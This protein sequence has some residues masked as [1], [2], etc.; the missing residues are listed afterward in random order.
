MRWIPRWRTGGRLLLLTGW[1]TACSDPEPTPPD[2][3]TQDAGTDAGTG[4][5]HGR[6]Q[7][8]RGSA[9][10]LRVRAPAGQHAAPGLRGRPLRLR[11][12]PRGARRPRDST[13]HH[14]AA[15]GL[16]R[17][18]D[19]REPDAGRMGPLHA[20]PS[21]LTRQPPCSLGGARSRGAADSLRGGGGLPAPDAAG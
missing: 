15:R 16:R 4:P 5:P 9:H 3:G 13:G 21:H 8:P 2:A 20:R 11:L 7:Q 19:A 17:A 10:P 18:P 12:V 6:V 14:P 1:L